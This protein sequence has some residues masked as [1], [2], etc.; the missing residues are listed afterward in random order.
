MFVKQ[1]EAYLLLI[2]CTVSSMPP[3]CQNEGV[4]LSASK[5]KMSG[6]HNFWEERVN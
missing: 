6:N 1:E 3:T 4:F 5:I 2:K